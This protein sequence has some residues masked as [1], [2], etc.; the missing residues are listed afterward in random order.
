[1]RNELAAR[2]LQTPAERCLSGLGDLGCAIRCCS[3][4]YQVKQPDAWMYCG[5][6][7]GISGIADQQDPL[8]AESRHVRAPPPLSISFMALQTGPGCS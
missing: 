4:M 2:R 7:V 5:Y 6:F 3:P 1:M 8:G